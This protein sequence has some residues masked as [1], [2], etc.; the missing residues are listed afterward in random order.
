MRNRACR[1]CSTN[2]LHELRA[3]RLS[4]LDTIEWL[5]K[6]ARSDLMRAL[7]TLRSRCPAIGPVVFVA[8]LAGAVALPSIGAG[9]YDDDYWQRRFLLDELSGARAVG[10]WKMFGV[11]LTAGVV[12]KLVYHG[13]LPWWASPRF[14]LSFF[15]PLAV[16]THYLDYWLWPTDPA[17][18][19][20]QNVVLYV[21]LCAAVAV[22]YRRVIA[23]GWTALMASVLYALDGAHLEAVAWVSARN[24]I[25]TALFCVLT[26]LAIE[27]AAKDPGWKKICFAT[28]AL[29][30]A[31][32]S[33]EGALAVWPY[34]LGTLL[35]QRNRGARLGCALP[36]V[37]VSVAF[38]LF[39]RHFNYVVSGTGAYIDPRQHLLAFGQAV[40]ERF[41][42]LLSTQLGPPAWFRSAAGEWARVSDALWIAIIGFVVWRRRRDARLA[43]FAVGALGAMLIVCTARPEPRLLLMAGV[44]AHAILALALQTLV[45]CAR[46]PVNGSLRW[47][48]AAGG[49]WIVLQHVVLPL[50][51]S[52]TV[53]ESYRLRQQQ[54]HLS[55]ADME[56]NDSDESTVVGILSTPSYFDALSTCTYRQE[57]SA[58]NPW[59]AVHILAASTGKIA[60]AR[61]AENSLMLEP[62]GGFLAEKTS[63]QARS[64]DEPFARGQTIELDGFDVIVDQTTDTGRP[65]RVRV[66]WPTRHHEPLTFLAWS[67]ERSTF[68][69]FELPAIGEQVRL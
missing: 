18:M 54:L 16:A 51:A 43:A 61:V 45:S 15:R 40:L 60:V 65:T 11:P 30:L 12:P 14:Q 50:P 8:L 42:V 4:R 33:S 48:A 62:E 2:G 56:L 49:A 32:L 67:Q 34:V 64:P 58:T 46:A 10:W 26:L 31:H 36:L 52:L 6:L 25:L 20:L 38:G 35:I 21:L 68:V 22:F 66:Q 39:T 1:R 19:H 7:G 44:G 9:L 29:A 37:A 17:C 23:S 41:P 69:H 28:V 47:L 63:Q 24:S 3:A 57:L 53:P 27:Q 13:F 59:R 5:V 55:A